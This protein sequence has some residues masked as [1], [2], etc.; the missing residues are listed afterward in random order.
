MTLD[1]LVIHMSPDPEASR[2]FYREL[3]TGLTSC[4]D[5]CRLEDALGHIAF[6]DEGAV[7]PGKGRWCPVFGVV[8]PDE[9]AGRVADAGGR[10]ITPLVGP[11]Q[12]TL[13]AVDDCGMRFGITDAAGIETVPCCITAELGSDD[14]AASGTFYERVLGTEWLAAND[15]PYGYHVMVRGDAV[16]AA[17][18]DITTFMPAT[19]DGE[20]MTYFEVADL[21][22][23][24]GKA[25]ELGAVV[26]IPPVYSPI[27]RYAVVTD[28]MG[29]TTGLSSLV[30][31]STSRTRFRRYR[32][33]DHSPDAAYD[34]INAT[35]LDYVGAYHDAAR[36]APH[37][38]H[39]VSP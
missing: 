4:V 37:Q 11:S 35:E 22:T 23:A 25:T 15:D 27:N 3:L 12:R 16:I 17:I 34:L 28:P 20:W 26:K 13:M 7:P 10:I 19:T 1:P 6:V 29:T 8:D 5:D 33:G 14:I 9:V 32:G 36:T 38:E 18:I 21:D 2:V 24:V 39:E 31:A 30:D